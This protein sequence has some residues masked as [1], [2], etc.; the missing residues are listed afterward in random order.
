MSHESAEMTTVIR[1]ICTVLQ[2]HHDTHQ[3]LLEEIDNKIQEVSDALDG[4]VDGEY[5]RV[6]LLAQKID[7]FEQAL[8]DRADVPANRSQLGRWGVIARLRAVEERI[9]ALEEYNGVP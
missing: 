5:Q 2:R 3:Y 6:T 4:H 1:E 8:R 9:K 7:T